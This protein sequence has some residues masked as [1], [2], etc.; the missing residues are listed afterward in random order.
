LSDG[1][2]IDDITPNAVVLKKV[3]IEE[4]SVTF[5][6][7]LLS[8]TYTAV[9]GSEVEVANFNIKPTDAE[10]VVLREIKFEKV[11]GTGISFDN[12]KVS[13][14]TL[15]MMN[16]SGEYVSIKNVGTNQLDG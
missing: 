11:A 3:Q 16:G 10:D 9:I 7:N 2:E 5:S 14:F 15:Y 1:I 6:Q 13:G 12:T 4:P 8:A